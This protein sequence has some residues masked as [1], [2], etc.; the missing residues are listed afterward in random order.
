MFLL[1][2]NYLQSSPLGVIETWS[3]GGVYVQLVPL[4]HLILIW[5]QL[6]SVLLARASA[7]QSVDFRETDWQRR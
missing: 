1:L 5:V 7:L 3:A 6:W 4:V 2:I